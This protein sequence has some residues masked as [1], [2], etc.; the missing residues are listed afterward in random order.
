MKKP[1]EYRIGLLSALVKSFL[2]L[3]LTL[4]V[5]RFCTR[6]YPEGLSK[7]ELCEDYEQVRGVA[8]YYSVCPVQGLHCCAMCASVTPVTA[9][10]DRVWL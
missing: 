9:W 2:W 6:L 10:P 8:D 4:T 5:P 1:C 7:L 3:V